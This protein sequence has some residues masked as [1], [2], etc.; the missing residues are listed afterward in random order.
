MFVPG[1]IYRKWVQLR[2]HY[3]SLTPEITSLLKQ[4]RTYYLLGLITNGPSSAQWEKIQKLDLENLFDIILVSG[5]LPYEKPNSKIFEKAC[6]FLG[7]EPKQCLMVGDKLETDILGGIRAE[8]GATVW[9][10]L[11]GQDQNNLELHPDFILRDVMELPSLLPEQP[12]VLRI[13]DKMK[14][15]DLDLEDSNSNSSDGS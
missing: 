2:Y 11:S 3:L 14:R 15:M 1:E 9:I 8:L 13:Q 7:V 12:K 4:L 5:D 10:P 6:G